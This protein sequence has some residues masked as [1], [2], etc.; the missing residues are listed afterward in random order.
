M[1]RTDGR[2]D[3]PADR[4]VRPTYFLSF[5][6]GVF[7]I[8][9]VALGLVQILRSGATG[10]FPLPGGPEALAAFRES[11]GSFGDTF[12]VVN[13]LFTG[14][15]FATIAASLILQRHDIGLALA[16]TRRG[17]DALR[18]Q[19]DA[20]A[21]DRE[22][23]ALAARFHAEPLKTA[24]RQA[25]LMRPAFFRSAAFRRLLADAWVGSEALRLPAAAVEAI[26]AHDAGRA[27][28]AE[29]AALERDPWSLADLVDHF[30]ALGRHVA[31]LAPQ[32]RAEAARRL[33]DGCDWPYWR[34][35]V[36]L[37]AD[38]TRRLYDETLAGPEARAACPRPA[39]IGDV[40]RFD[41]QAM[42]A[43]NPYVPN[44]H[45]R[46]TAHGV[47]DAAFDWPALVAWVDGAS[48]GAADDRGGG[49]GRRA[50]PAPPRP[51]LTPVE[52]PARLVA[53]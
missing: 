45:P 25:G 34:G 14:L 33:S 18:R 12:A 4:A 32:D 26:R 28:P 46:E 43:D 49:D 37:L 38:E 15:A 10:A 20:L 52:A 9:A 44:L 29:L 50:P 47:T 23:A 1:T 30:A 22:A 39:W 5:A 2:G 35:T 51:R 36:L 13:A 31:T 27:A 48:D 40:V 19:A 11:W 17:A 6:L 41:R 21:R 3:A 42:G 7:V 8:W 24:R 53:G 16:E